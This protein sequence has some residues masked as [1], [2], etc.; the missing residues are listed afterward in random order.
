[1]SEIKAFLTAALRTPRLMR[2]GPVAVLEDWR[3][4][5]GKR[6]A[7]TAKL[8]KYLRGLSPDDVYCAGADVCNNVIDSYESRFAEKSLREVKTLMPGSG[9]TCGHDMSGWSYATMYDA[10]VRGTDG[11][12]RLKELRDLSKATWVT[13]RY[14]WPK[15][16]TWGEDL[17]LRILGG[18]TREVSAHWAFDLAVCSICDDDMRKCDHYPGEE[19]DGKK[20][21][22]EIRN[23]T[24]YIETA[25]VVKGGQY[26]TSTYPVEGRG[27]QIVPFDEAIREMKS[28]REWWSDWKRSTRTIVK[29]TEARSG[30]GGDAREYFAKAL[31]GRNAA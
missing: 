27:A 25:F 10:G 21:W 2:T 28:H 4:D 30:K 11:E 8:G 1:M 15:K 24:D 22:Y 19:Y 3:A 20:C 18:V 9:M 7:E 31:A 17:S 13:G 12:T 26:G 23:V 16:A 14:Y 6:A 5:E 29:E